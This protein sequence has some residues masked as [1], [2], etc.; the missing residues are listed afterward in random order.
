[1]S[2]SIRS[3]MS[4]PMLARQHIRTCRSSSI[5]SVMSLPLNTH[6]HPLMLEDGDS[7][8]KEYIFKLKAAGCVVSTD[9]VMV[10]T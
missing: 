7:Q 2:S 5:S 4:M 3:E 9:V 8:V 10:V 6:G 1:M